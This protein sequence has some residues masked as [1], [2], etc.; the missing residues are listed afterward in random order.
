MTKG[1]LDGV[2]V[3]GR[4]IKPVAFGLSV[5]MLTL[6][7]YNI[8]NVGVFGSLFLGDVIAV[9][10][11]TSFVML[12]LGWFAKNQ[13]LAEFGLITAFTAYTLRA[14]FIL[15]SSGPTAEGFYLSIGAA[16]IAGGA[17]LLEGWDHIPKRRGK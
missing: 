5:L 11:G 7:V 12:M 2:Q 3:W 6:T 1:D 13:L 9:L 16:I 10:T 15:F 8:F 17:Y 14:S 4:P